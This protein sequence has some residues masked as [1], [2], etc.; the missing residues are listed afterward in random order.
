MYPPY[1]NKGRPLCRGEC[2]NGVRPCPYV[3]CRYHLYLDINEA[4]GSLKINFPDKE[5]DELVETCALDVAERGRT[6]L[7]RTG[8]LL[9]MTRERVR[10]LVDMIVEELRTRAPELHEDIREHCVERERYRPATLQ[11]KE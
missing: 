2:R 8:Y 9:N 10:Q 4:T 7:E 6:S 1:L 11:V 3:S 5:P